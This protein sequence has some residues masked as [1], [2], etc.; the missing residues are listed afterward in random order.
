MVEIEESG[1]NEPVSGDVS[2]ADVRAKTLAAIELNKK[3]DAASN[4]NRSRKSRADDARQT[5]QANDRKR[6]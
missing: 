2:D 1:T 5:P 6:D 4:N 3:P